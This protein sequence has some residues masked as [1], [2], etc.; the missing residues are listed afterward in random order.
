MPVVPD[1]PASDRLTETDLVLIDAL[2]SAP[3][4]PWSRIAEAT[5]T[6]ASTAARRWE[7]LR[8]KG[9]A[10][11][12]AYESADSVVVAHVEISCAA[13]EVAAN[14]DRLARLPWVVSVYEVAGD[15][16]LLITVGA[17]DLPGI[18]GVVR[19]DVS[20]LPGVE[21][22][23]VR[24]AMTQYGE[25][26]DWRM[27]AL[28]NAERVRLPQRSPVGCVSF[29][30]TGRDRYSA[31]DRELLAVLGRDGRIGH[32]AL[33]QALGVSEHTA[34]RR[35]RKLLVDGRVVLRCDFAQRLA[36]LTT[37]VIYRARVPHADCDE[38]GA[39]LARLEAVRLCVS[40]SGEENLFV[41]ALLHGLSGAAPF[42][43]SVRDRMPTGGVTAR[44]V[45]LRA[46]KRVGWVLDEHER[47][48][49]YVPPQ[50]PA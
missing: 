35:L 37:S 7:R 45:V 40:V 17:F 28:S 24:L 20:T 6:A 41:H 27:R 47:A 42:E 8:D 2:Q 29:S 22:A 18:R 14:A 9:M 13:P 10:W 25:G 39:A 15:Y 5:G 44:T 50:E 49:F 32:R 19:D 1:L 48:V 43:A 46:V 34:A 31:A 3:R 4:S 23:R 26:G 11:V 21:Q 38:V 16:D 30:D 36:G 12:T 33:G